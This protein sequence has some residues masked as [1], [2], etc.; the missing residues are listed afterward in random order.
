M[1]ITGESCGLVLNV[2]DW[3][4]EPEFLSWLNNPPS[5]VMTWHERDT[6]AGE[7]SDTVVFV[8]PGLQ[9]EGTDSDMPEKYWE[10]IV[11]ACRSRFRPGQSQDHLVVRLTNLD[12]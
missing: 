1:E 4:Q 3:F 8:D 7:C 11:D 6:P 10:A 12:G 2:P 5:P 9:G